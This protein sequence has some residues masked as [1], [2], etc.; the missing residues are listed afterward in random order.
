M[1]K[2]GHQEHVFMLYWATIVTLVEGKTNKKAPLVDSFVLNR[3]QTILFK[4]FSA[5][6]LINQ[7]KNIP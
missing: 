3:Q 6:Y 7:L 2:D 1:E 5:V 4:S